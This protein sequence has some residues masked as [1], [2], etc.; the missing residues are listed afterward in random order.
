M[1]SDI[2]HCFQLA[3]AQWPVKLSMFLCACFSF[4]Y[5]LWR[6]IYS[7]P[8]PIFK[9][10]SSVLMLP[11]CESSFDIREGNPIWYVT[12]KYFLQFCSLS[13][14]CL[15]NVLQCTKVLIFNEVQFVFFPLIACDFGVKS[16]NPWTDLRSQR[17]ILMFSSNDFIVLS[18]IETTLNSFRFLWWLNMV[19]TVPHP[20]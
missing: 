2:C 8:L 6:C 5:F 7:S 19:V 12:C 3:F 10:G 13:F 1:W 15:E 17:I 18:V 16:E 20:L 4:A 9:T 14:L 11:N